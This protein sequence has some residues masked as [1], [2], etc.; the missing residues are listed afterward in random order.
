MILVFNIMKI[1]LF[2]KAF[3]SGDFNHTIDNMIYDNI[4]KKEKV[5]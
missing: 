2:I 4:Y 3:V 1:A 5:H